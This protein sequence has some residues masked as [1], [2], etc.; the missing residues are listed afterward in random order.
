ME[1][2]QKRENLDGHVAYI[3]SVFI[4]W[5]HMLVAGGREKMPEWKMDLQVVL[6]AYY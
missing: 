5:P 2:K 6:P 1:K 3:T 4:C